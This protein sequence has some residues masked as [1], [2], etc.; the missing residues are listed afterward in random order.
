MHSTVDNLPKLIMFDVYLSSVELSL[1]IEKIKWAVL[2]HNLYPLGQEIKYLL[3]HAKYREEYYQK[4]ITSWLAKIYLDQWVKVDMLEIRTIRKAWK[5]HGSAAAAV[6]NRN[7]FS[8]L[9]IFRFLC[10]P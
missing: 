3:L 5:A 9:A 8:V 10:H 1:N 7:F 2:Y 6:I 4:D